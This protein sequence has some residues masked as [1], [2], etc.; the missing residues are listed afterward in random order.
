MFYCIDHYFFLMAPV[1]ISLSLLP[2]ICD[3][4]KFILLLYWIN[5]STNNNNIKYLC[6]AY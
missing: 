1:D 2:F 5:K 4:V 6:C 3:N